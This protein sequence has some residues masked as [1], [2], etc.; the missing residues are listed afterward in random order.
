MSKLVLKVVDLSVG[1]GDSEN[2]TAA[3]H[4]INF[5]IEAGEIYALVGESGSGK[6][7]TAMAL[8]NLLPRPGGKVLSGQVWH[9]EQDLLAESAHWEQARGSQIAYIFQEPSLAMNPVRTVGSQMVECAPQHSDSQRE[10]LLQQV[11]FTDTGRILRS[12]PH[13]LSGGQLQRVMIAMALLTDPPILVADEPTTAL[14][15]TVQAQVMELLCQ[16]CQERNIALLLITHNLALVSTYAQR[17]GVMEKGY[18]VEEGS[19]AQIIAQ[20][21]HTYTQALLQ[22]VPHGS[23]SYGQRS[24]ISEQ[25][26][27]QVENLS[28]SYPVRGGFWGRVQ[29][30]VH[31]VQ[32]VDLTLHAGEILALVGESGCGKSTLAR[33]L[34]GMHPWKNGTMTLLDTKIAWTE[35]EH[36]ELVRQNMQMVFQDPYGSLNPRQTVAELLTWPLRARGITGNAAQK[37]ALQALDQ[38]QLERNSMERFPHAFSGGQRQRIGIARALALQSKIIICDEPTSALDVSVQ[39]QILRLLQQ[40]R[41]ELGISLLFISHDLAVVQSLCDRVMVMYEGQVVEHAPAAQL[42]ATPQHAYTQKLLA[43]APTIKKHNS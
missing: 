20:P 43:S 42:F 26:I 23:K 7:V 38:V 5:H 29:N 31:A 2:H 16:L 40:L 35:K 3:T 19:V 17:V 27:L 32:N 30:H 41:Q 36:R 6:T 37:M 28:V 12:Y 13:E 1:F 14:D 34:L 18:L 15:V 9:Q 8:T 10:E 4:G 21:Q 39:D 22:A 11:G 33:S 24:E 25:S